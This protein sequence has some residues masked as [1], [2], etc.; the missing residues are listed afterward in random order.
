MRDAIRNVSNLSKAVRE[1]F[2][3]KMKARPQARSTY[4]D[5]GRMT[6]LSERVGIVGI[7][8]NM[9]EYVGMCRNVSECVGICRNGRRNM[10]ENV[11][12]LT[13]LSA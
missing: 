12:N 6:D 10:S 13:I 4:S 1:F 2:F 11:G 9:S 5:I 8:R 3:N 7:C